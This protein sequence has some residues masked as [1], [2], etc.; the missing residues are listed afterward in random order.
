MISKEEIKTISNLKYVGWG[1]LSNKFLTELYHHK[2]HGEVVNIMTMLRETNDNLMQLLSSKYDFVKEIEKYNSS[3]SGIPGKIEYEMLE[4]LYVS[5]AVRRSIWQT[6][7][8][9]RELVKVS[10]RD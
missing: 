7:E 6:I 3:L 8:I 4:D 10:K 9:T 5:P 1:R 2:D